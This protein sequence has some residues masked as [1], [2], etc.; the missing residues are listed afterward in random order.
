MRDGLFGDRYQIV[1]EIG[2]G[3]MGLVYEVEDRERGERVALK[4]LRNPSPDLIYRFKSEFRALAELSHPNLITLYDL[5]VG[6]HC[7]FTMELLQGTDFLTYVRQSRGARLADGDTEVDVRTDEAVVPV[8]SAPA[9]SP[10]PRDLACDELRLRAVLPQLARGL[11][12]LHQ[13]GKVHRDIKPQN[14]IVTPEGRLVLLDFGLAIEHASAAAVD[15]QVGGVVGTIAY[16]SPEQCRGD[17]VG[18]ATDWYAMGVLLYEALT[19]QL[20]FAGSGMQILM[21]KQEHVPA[22]PRALVPEV[23]HDL[24]AL[25]VH[26]LALEPDDRPSGASVLRRLG[27]DDRVSGTAL[28]SA[29]G[30]QAGFFAGRID[31]LAALEHAL[32]RL[33]AAQVLELTGPSGVGKSALV[34]RFLERARVTRPGL[35]AL[36]GRCY[37]RETV[38]YKAMDGVIDQLSRYWRALPSAVAASLLPSHTSLLV[39]L[40]P[41]LGR[42]PAVASAPPGPPIADPQRV[43]TGAFAALRSLLDRLARRSPT[44]LV[45]DDLQWVDA[46]TIALLSDLMRSPDPPPLLLILTAREEGVSMLDGLMQRTSLPSERIRL[47]ALPGHEADELARVLLGASERAALA[48]H[49][50]RAAEGN[51]FFIGELVRYVLATEGELGPL[52]LQSVLGDRIGQLPRQARHILELIALSGEPLSTQVALSASELPPADFERQLRLLRVG[53]L[54]GLASN[55]EGHLEAYHSRIREAAVA[56]L[57]ATRLEQLHRLL[58][59]ALAAQA[60]HEQ[61]ARHWRGAGDPERASEHAIKAAQASLERLDF[62][63]AA[64]LFDLALHCGNHGLEERRRLLV[65]LASAQANAGRPADA[66]HNYGLAAE[67]APRAE[68]L[69]L[70]RV[71]AEELLRGGYVRQGMDAVSAVLAD[72]GMKLARTPLLALLSVIARHAW[73]R[74]RG[75]R[76]TPT[77]ASQLPADALIRADTYWSVGVGLAI[78]DTIRGADYRQRHLL[79]AL[80]LGEPVRVARAMAMEAGYSA[81][82]ESERRALSWAA[83]AEEAALRYEDPLALGIVQ[84][85]RGLVTYYHQSNWPA[86]LARLTEAEDLF[87]QHVRAAGWEVDTTQL[88]TCFTLLYLGQIEE[89]HRR[90]SSYLREAER[91][92]DRYAMVNLRGRLSIVWLAQ[93]DPLEAECAIEEAEA[94]WIPWR[95]SFQTQHYWFLI[96]R[97][98]LAL[99]RGDPMAAMS[100]LREQERAVRRSFLL[101]VGMVRIEFAFVWARLQLAH[102]SRLPRA[103]AEARRC[104]RD[105]AAR[106][107]ELQRERSPMSHDCAR[108]V[109]AGVAA[110][111][112][113]AQAATDQ[114]VRALRGFVARQEGLFSAAAR[115]RL[116]TLIGGPSGVAHTEEAER[117]FR[118]QGVKN[119]HRMVDMLAP[120]WPAQT[121]LDTGPPR[122]GELSQGSRVFLVDDDELVVE[123]AG[124]ALRNA[125]FQV[126]TRTEAHGT[127]QAILEARP[128]IVVLDV[129]M[130]GIGGTSIAKILARR[131]RPPPVIVLHSSLAPE[132]LERMR[133]ECGAA[134]AMCKAEGPLALVSGVQA[135]VAGTRSR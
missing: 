72:L 90:F 131:L 108:L 100:L 49:V 107:R 59:T 115:W 82:I 119:P 30:T 94:A 129:Q 15:S 128:D 104:L 22:P 41:V 3:G 96:S 127:A 110:V 106:T 91:R 130:P 29:P 54:V 45:L 55:A 16:M 48:P 79:L 85:A 112:G 36:Q 73:I 125:G 68:S 62:D 66:A 67:G 28:A 81:V 83:R 50:A 92:G 69:E 53:H 135:L 71:A 52:S 19:G 20:P 60:S 114:L 23:P 38:A 105:V 56:G 37:E 102:A 51:P 124:A 84:L 120:G 75:A 109:A 21:A 86:A 17:R 47:G 103:S 32:A 126:T 18:P 98:E 117:F 122:L 46:D 31:E 123:I 12:T 64:Q 63:R 25:S 70:R 116:G 42:V 43:R 101:R 24:D 5:F 6:E 111:E 74:L 132:P 58:A 99:Y 9:P 61:L 93:D 134:A 95:E 4:T 77:E 1:R 80:R 44:V 88:F 97:C 121:P 7:F 133:R 65:G 13:G 113:D 39:R 10:P 57:S 35:V 87:K 2:H 27:V 78:V 34:Q 14:L 8:V 118:S 11:G 40:F 89:L 76:W 26:L 33:P